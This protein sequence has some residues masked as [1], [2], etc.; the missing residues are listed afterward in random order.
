VHRTRIKICGVTR[1][2]DAVAAVELGADAIGI[3]LH[4]PARRYVP[5]ERAREIAH[6]V[7]AFT[8]T[9]G[10]FVDRDPQ[11]LRWES[12]IAGVRV[13]QLHGNETPQTV[14]AEVAWTV[15]KAVKVRPGRLADDLR[16]WRRSAFPGPMYNL[17][18]LVLETDTAA[19]GGTGV[20]NDWDEIA[21]ARDAGAFEGLP[22]II[23]AG[24]LTPETVADV[25]R[26]LRPY[27]VDVSSGVEDGPVGVKSQARIEA[28]V[29]AVREADNS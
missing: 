3:V 11:Q 24:G 20:A 9:V 8:T 5:P 21:R 1:V 29:R 22:P 15:V 10:L 28:F 7:P 27:A 17:A 26:R 6:A 19:P 12:S 23:A 13:V 4:P 2:E 16:V 18:G 25:V 14:A